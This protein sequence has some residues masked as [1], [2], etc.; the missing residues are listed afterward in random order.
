M[1]IYHIFISNNVNFA[2]R[3]CHSDI[4]HQAS[5]EPNDVTSGQLSIVVWK[6]STFSEERFVGISEAEP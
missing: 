3:K 2:H 4:C 1:Y 5:R 6:V